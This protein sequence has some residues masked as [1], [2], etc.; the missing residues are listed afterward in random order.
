MKIP[1]PAEPVPDKAKEYNGFLF[2]KSFS[3]DPA[4]KCEN[5]PHLIVN[6]KTTMTIAGLLDIPFD[7]STLGDW[8]DYQQKG[9]NTSANFY[10]QGKTG[11]AV[12]IA[13]GVLGQVGFL[14]YDDRFTV[15]SKMTFEGRNK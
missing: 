4:Y 15:I 6:L 9:A 5:I 12:E 2:A 8:L 10:S 13:N 1:D 7:K 11:Q 14:M 3:E